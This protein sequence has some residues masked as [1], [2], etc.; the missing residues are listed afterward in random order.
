MTLAE[1]IRQY[2]AENPG[3]TNTHLAEVFGV[4]R[5]NV[6]AI[7]NYA[8]VRA[9]TPTMERREIGRTITKQPIYGYWVVGDKTA[10]KAKQEA[11][12]VEER[13]PSTKKPSTLDQ[14]VDQI[15]AQLAKQVVN[16]V[17]TRLARE[18]EAMLPAPQHDQEPDIAPLIERLSL[19]AHVDVG[20]KRLPRVGIVGLM[21]VQ[22]G[23][24]TS[25]FADA[26]DLRFA[27]TD[28][29]ANLAALKGCDVIFL[30]TRHMSHAADQ[31][32]KTLGVELRRVTGGVS[33]MRDELTNYFVKG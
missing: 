25:E 22:A 14:L 20:V 21:P 9:I 15:A 33:K 26:L 27:N 24:L 32:L 30:H 19:P 28:K 6:A 29:T 5:N 1:Q 11:P 8:A 23:E 31:Y 12:F 2:L 13:V 4:N 3:V 16:K 10:P 7:T 17:K 18:L